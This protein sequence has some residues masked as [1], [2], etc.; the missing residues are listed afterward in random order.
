[1]FHFLQHQITQL[2]W[3]CVLLFETV[4]QS[5]SQINCQVFIVWTV[6]IWQ[7][8]F[9]YWSFVSFALVYE[10]FVFCLIFIK[11][12]H[13][14]CC[15]ANFGRPES[16]HSIWVLSISKLCSYF[17]SNLIERGICH[18]GRNQPSLWDFQLFRSTISQSGYNFTQVNWKAN[19]NLFN[20]GLIPAHNLSAEFCFVLTGRADFEGTKRQFFK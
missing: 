6:V 5:S 4:V 2:T 17:A 10:R 16:P 15:P 8:S 3:K 11:T 7:W 20:N 1:M 14:H 12:K 19:T 18:F 9:S 13:L